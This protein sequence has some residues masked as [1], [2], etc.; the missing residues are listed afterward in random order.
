MESMAVK[1]IGRKNSFLTRGSIRVIYKGRNFWSG[2]NM[3]KFLSVGSL[4]ALLLAACQNDANSGNS[5][6]EQ[7]LTI[8]EDVQQHSEWELDVTA[9]ELAGIEE[10]IMYSI[11]TDQHGTQR[12]LAFRCNSRKKRHEFYIT[13]ISRSHAGGFYSKLKVDDREIVTDFTTGMSD[14]VLS[15]RR[16]DQY[17]LLRELS[18]MKESAK[19]NLYEF[20]EGTAVY[21]FSIDGAGFQAA[22][23][24]L[25]E[26]CRWSAD[27]VNPFVEKFNKLNAGVA[28][29]DEELK[30]FNKC[31]KEESI[32]EDDENYA[33]F[34]IECLNVESYQ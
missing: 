21:Q 16:G 17:K 9:D 4:C 19:L 20:E 12:P 15:Y 7:T 32:F 33:G 24:K 5:S 28:D 18:E 25:P 30:I 3:K 23:A 27:M 31:K 10:Y 1:E 8:Q 11:V 26:Y 2:E 14:G 29:S 22:N 13:K 6:E 34:V